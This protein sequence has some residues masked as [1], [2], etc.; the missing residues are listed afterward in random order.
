MDINTV[1]NVIAALS[2]DQKHE[3]IFNHQPPPLTFLVHSYMAAIGFLLIGLRSTHGCVIAQVWML[4]FV[5][6]VLSCSNLM[7]VQTKVF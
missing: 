3:L 1:C 5:G 2:N 7:S 6:Y 4:Y